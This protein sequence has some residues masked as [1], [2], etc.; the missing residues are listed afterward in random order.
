MNKKNALVLSGGGT[1]GAIEV[2]FYK[3]IV[4]K[5]IKIDLIVG[6]SIGAV[7][8]AFI[9]DGMSP[10]DL[11]LLWQNLSVQDLYGVNWSHLWKFFGADSLYNHS[12]FR[13]FLDRHLTCREIE[14]L[15][16]PL[17]VPCTNL[18]TGAPV[19]L[20]KGSLLDALMASVAMPGIFS[21]QEIDGVQMVDGGVADNLPLDV[22]VFEGATTILCMNY[23]YCGD[24]RVPV[25]GLKRVM[26]RAFSI[27][28]DRKTDADIRYFKDKAKLI[29]LEPHFGFD[30][31]LLD[32]R[33]TSLL[34]DQAYEF[35]LETLERE[36]KI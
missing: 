1:K 10:G 11:A 15:K 29:V 30:I 9:A 3:A 22:A 13:G 25:H 24:V 2:G 21:P 23:T 6:T 16:I 35:S 12:R 19:Y 7:N 33:Y 17:I 32:F 26:S 31:D 34:I 20:R 27:A 36:F 28:M 14:N 18:H 4:E 5:G 8:G